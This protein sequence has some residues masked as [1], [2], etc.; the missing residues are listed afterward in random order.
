[1]FWI[2]DDF[3]ADVLQGRFETFDAALENLRLITAL[4]FGEAP[5]C[6]PCSSWI[7]CMRVYHIVEYDNPEKPFDQL[8]N[9]KTVEVSAAGTTW[10]FTQ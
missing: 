7:N 4:P 9:C 6:P 10:F 2:E 3:H 1:M 8:I 5:N